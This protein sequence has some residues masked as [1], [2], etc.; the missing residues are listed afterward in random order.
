ME[1]IRFVFQHALQ[2]S[3]TND[4]QR[5]DTYLKNIES[6]FRA[7][8]YEG[9]A[10]NLALKNIQDR[11]LMDWRAFARRSEPAYVPHIHVGLGWAIAKQ[12]L[13]SLVFLDSLKP[14]LMFRVLDGHGYYDGIFRQVQTINSQSRPASIELYYHASYDQGVGRS[15]WYA[16]GGH[17]DRVAKA[18]S[19]FSTERHSAL[20]R[21]VGIAAAFVGGC[22]E[23]K[24]YS[25]LESASNHSKHL[26]FG[27]A[28]AVKARV[29]TDTVGP[30]TNLACQVLCNTSV[31]RANALISTLE[32]SSAE[33][34]YPLFMS[35]LLQIESQ[36]AVEGK[37]AGVHK[38][39]E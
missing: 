24:L 1:K 11:A 32:S 12:K 19:A 18:V 35:R 8:A 23:S 39:N 22:D 28:M 10:M 37:A 31:E 25:L 5:V 9:V 7:V 6:E 36:L 15:L 13:S 2:F 3:S 17:V 16:A 4:E 34:T 27:A 33:E 29:F 14:S 20:W 38:E 21:G 30:D 26:G